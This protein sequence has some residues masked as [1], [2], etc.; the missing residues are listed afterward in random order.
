[1]IRPTHVVLVVYFCV[2]GVNRIVWCSFRLLMVSEHEN[3][4]FNQIESEPDVGQI[5]QSQNRC[6]K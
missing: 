2:G 6:K 5:A 3:I 4:E 1:M